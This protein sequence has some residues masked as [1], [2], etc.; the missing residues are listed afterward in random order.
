MFT[1]SRDVGTIDYMLFPRSK[2][3]AR[4]SD[5]DFAAVAAEWR[6]RALSGDQRACSIADALESVVSMRAQPNQGGVRLLSAKD[7]AALRSFA[8]RVWVALNQPVVMRGWAQTV[9]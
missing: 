7:A 1:L 8:A 3:H 5:S 6:V 4:L 9:S 2:L